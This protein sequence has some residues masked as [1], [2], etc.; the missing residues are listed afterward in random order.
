MNFIARH[1]S[2]IGILLLT[3]FVGAAAGLYFDVP[4]RLQKLRS[5]SS[6]KPT[7]TCPMHAD[8]VQEHPGDCPQCGMA[9]VPAGQSKSAPDPCGNNGENHPGCCA[10]KSAA[11]P[12][13]QL[14]LPP[15]HPP[16]PGWT[17]EAHTNSNCEPVSSGTTTH[18]S[19]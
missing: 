10:N 13:T 8:V 3:V 2:L 17:V 1:I 11:Q 18:S 9:L 7:Y 19:P 4:A 14:R 16:V 12:A 5:A 6:A 15:G